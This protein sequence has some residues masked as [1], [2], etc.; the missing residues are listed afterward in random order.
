VNTPEPGDKSA[1]SQTPEDPKDNETG[2][3]DQ[4][5]GGA[6]R[7]IARFGGQRPM[8]SKLGIAV[9][10]V[11]GWKLRN[12]IPENRHAD[13]LA[14]A[15]EHGIDLD[16][17]D[18]ADLAPGAAAEDG[19]EAAESAGDAAAEAEP[20]EDEAARDEAPAAPVAAASPAA[21]PS[22]SGGGRFAS[23]VLVGALALAIGAG[24]AVLTRDQWLPVVGDPGTTGL[25]A[26]Q[27]RVS[28]LERR[29]VAGPDNAGDPATA[30]ALAK[31]DGR[32]GALD[33]QLGEV[34]SRTERLVNDADATAA[35]LVQLSDAIE[36]TGA[37]VDGL[38]DRL[39]ALE[40]DGVAGSADLEGLRQELAAGQGRLA[41]ELASLQAKLD[42]VA[43]QAAAGSKGAEQAALAVAVGQLRAVTR[44]AQPFSAEL[45]NLQRFVSQDSELSTLV[46]GL[47]GPAV[48]GVATLEE[49]RGRFPEVAG[50]IVGASYGGDDESWIGDALRQL[51]DIGTIRRIGEIDG[52]SAAA[53]VARAEQDLMQGDL[54]AAV[55]ELAA[56]SGP[57]AEAAAGWLADARARQEVEAALAALT[58][59]VIGGL[60]VTGG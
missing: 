24:G 20:K 1:T 31:L 4:P 57:P 15:K 27:D 14:T 42:E 40:T 17:A 58:R 59:A 36:A 19:G 9:S 53:H 3:D 30:E 28:E 6:E 60:S 23:G 18:F 45:A 50:E 2:G 39:S 49:L 25:A 8:A 33:G 43:V 21:A 44:N 52:D 32:L 13:I 26:L 35:N 5:T 34:S 46:A 48:T 51:S 38:G 56:L 41:A 22:E 37:A 55:S 10:T 47:A 29:P 7:I 54:A 11:Q 12:H 16:E